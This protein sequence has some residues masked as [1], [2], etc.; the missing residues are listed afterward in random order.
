MMNFSL[1]RFAEEGISK[2][3]DIEPAI[4]I[5]HATRIGESI[6]GLLE[7]MEIAD[8]EPLAAGSTI[9]IYKTEIKNEP[10]QV[11]EGETITLTKVENKVARTVTL[12]LNKYRRK[13]TAEAIQRSGRDI[14][15]NACDEKLAGKVRKD[16]K[17]SFYTVM[18]AGEGSATGGATLQ[19]TLAAVWAEVQKFYEDQDVTPLYVVSAED[20]ADYLATATV[21]TQS[22]FGFQ[23]LQNFLGLGDA[24]VSP[25]LTNGKVI[26]TAKENLKAYYVP[27]DAGDVAELFGTTADESG[28]VGITHVPSIDD[29]SVTT[30]MLAGVAIY[31]EFLDGV[32]VSTINKG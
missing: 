27:A 12:P 30:L 2:T 6:N 18:E 32:I 25:S 17:K 24:I 5:D 19:A 22:V 11:A 10:E 13:T 15:I 3:T 7:V 21:S 8:A 26:G 16:V 31:P 23:Y 1:Q 9:K 14:A 4:S 29:A 28:F 20:V